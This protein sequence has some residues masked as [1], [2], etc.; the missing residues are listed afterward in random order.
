M[1]ETLVDAV[2]KGQ[3]RSIVV[4]HTMR[5]AM[6]LRI[7][8]MAMLWG[9][10]GALGELQLHG[11][12]G[13]SVAGEPRIRFLGAELLLHKHGGS[14]WLNRDVGLFIDG[15]TALI[16]RHQQARLDRLFDGVLQ[17]QKADWL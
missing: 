4:T 12:D 9:R 6:D 17:L 16:P 13:I 15:S 1:L 5:Y 7:T 10:K 8:A 3:P 11:Q 2:C 14:A